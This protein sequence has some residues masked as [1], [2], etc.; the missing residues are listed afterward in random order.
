MATDGI[1]QFKVAV[2]G[3]CASG[4]STLVSFLRKKGYDARHVAQEHSYVPSMWQRISRPDVLIYL[5]ID[6]GT[7]TARR[8]WLNIQP[9]DLVEQNRRLH[10]ALEHC[11]L[12]I[13]T[14]QLNEEEV[15]GRALSFLRGFERAQNRE[16]YS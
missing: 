4:K 2:V 6:Y 12:Y 11:H 7:V 9:D 16:N 13:D 1:P 10:H 8:P 15:Q 3:A 5:D 14:N